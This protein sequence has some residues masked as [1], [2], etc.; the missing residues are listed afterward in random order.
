VHS[1][2]D[3][4][5]VPGTSVKPGAPWILAGQKTKLGLQFLRFEVQALSECVVIIWLCCTLDTEP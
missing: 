2:G 5:S 3:A 1:F 4:A